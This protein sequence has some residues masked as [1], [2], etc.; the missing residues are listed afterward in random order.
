MNNKVLVELLV[1]EME[2]SYDVFLPINKRVGNVVNLLNKMVSELTNDCY[3]GSNKTAL[4]NKDTKKKY[5]SNDLIRS[6]PFK[7]V[8]LVIPASS[9]PS[10]VKSEVVITQALQACLLRI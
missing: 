2:A 9:I 8:T 7:S 10:G 6:F 3:V 5:N 4:Y 1:P